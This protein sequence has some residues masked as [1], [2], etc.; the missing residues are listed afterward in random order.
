MKTKLTLGILLLATALAL[1]ASYT[2]RC[3]KCGNIQ[4]F[5]RP[6]PGIKC[7]RDGWIMVPQ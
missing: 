5:D 4:T 7:S 6:S 1:A 3:P 2:Y